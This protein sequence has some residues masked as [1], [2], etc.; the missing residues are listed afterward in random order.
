MSRDHSKGETERSTDDG[1][2]SNPT[3]DA[4][5]PD[6]ERSDCYELPDLSTT[7]QHFYRAEM[8]RVT[9]WRG[10][11]DQTTNWAVTIMAAILTWVFT[12]PDNPH[13][14]LLIGIGT[15][16]VFLVIETRRYCM[17]DVWRSRVRLVEQNVV[18]PILSP[19]VDTEH[20]EWRT[21]LA[22]DLREPALKV[23]F[24]EAFARR[25][26]R[27]YLPL[28]Y[29]LLA[30]WIVRITIFARDRTPVEGAGAVSIPGEVVLAAVAGF[31]VA[32]SAVAFWPQD[33]QAKGELYER[34]KEGE[35]KEDGT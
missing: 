27:I 4:T 33:R 28:L 16:A 13:Y 20:E 12:S 23:P 31:Y 21:E 10:R 34:E 17:Y 32:L 35:W 30:A 6:P 24:R 15:V 5:P 3:D 22:H 9:T 18:A 1:G 29:V 8:D 26:R 11:L 2:H 14:I 7:I 19:E 25:L